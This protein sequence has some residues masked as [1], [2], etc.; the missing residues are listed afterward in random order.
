MTSASVGTSI[1]LTLLVLAGPGGGASAARA[2]LPSADEVDVDASGAA[3]DRARAENAQLRAALLR[4]RARS[5]Q[6]RS[7]LARQGR[8]RLERELAWQDFQSQLGNLRAGEVAAS[9]LAALLGLRDDSDRARS[10]VH[11]DT[12]DETLT[13]A[14]ARADEVRRRLCAL[15]RVEGV[16]GFDVFDLG[17]LAADRTESASKFGAGPVVLRLLDG[18]GALAGSISADRLH[19]EASRTGH[20]VTLVL[21]DG[22][23]HESG[24]AS[25]FQGGSY[26]IPLR[27]VDP[28]PFLDECTALFDPD[29]VERVVDDG[30]WNRSAV[31][32]ALDRSLGA[33]A[34]GRRYRLE[35][36]GGVVD[37]ELREV[38]IAVLDDDGNELR[39]LVADGLG[40]EI[41]RDHVRLVLR[42]GVTTRGDSRVPFLDGR[43]TLVLPGAD[44]AAWRAA[45]V[46]CVRDVAPRNE[47]RTPPEGE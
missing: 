19:L 40:V 37:G 18:R 9:E 22:S 43:M 10:E 26:R 3:L 32:L 13:A 2:V 31:R 11:R 42:D 46:P 27:H 36:L 23:I 33:T 5:G 7:E 25:P 20:S 24:A 39:R 12:V 44:P 4:E 41:E 45:N 28:A 6:L 38:E 15:L 16:R 17:V 21:T 30:R 8:A 14:R 1:V 35:W 29:V 34:V 47:R